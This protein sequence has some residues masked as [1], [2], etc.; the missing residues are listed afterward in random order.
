MLARG[1]AV[2]EWVT[3]L[4]FLSAATRLSRE[5][6]ERERLANGAEQSELL[7]TNKRRDES[8]LLEKDASSMY[9]EEEGSSIVKRRAMI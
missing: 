6:S 5:E 7:N 4:L 8:R 1:V 2:R 3:P 9:V